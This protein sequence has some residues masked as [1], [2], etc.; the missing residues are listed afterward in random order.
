MA[1]DLRTTPQAICS[2]GMTVD[3]RVIKDEHIQQMAD[4]YNAR[5]Y[6]ARINLD[7]E[8]EWGGWLAKNIYAIDLNGGMLGDVVEVRAEKNEDGVLCLYAILSPNASFVLLNQSGQAV[9]YSAEVDFDFQDTGMAY[10]VGLAATDYPACCYTTRANFNSKTR[11]KDAV[12]NFKANLDFSD[13]SPLSTSQ[14]REQKKPFSFR[15]LFSQKQD[16][17]MKPEELASALKDAL[18]EPIANLTAAVTKQGETIEALSQKVNA[19]ATDGSGDD[20]P[21]EGGQPPA[22]ESFSAED[23]KAMQDTITKLSDQVNGLAEKLNTAL[24]TGAGDDT[25][26]A[27]GSEGMDKVL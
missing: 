19:A 18:G 21:A 13:L 11:I 8:G 17:E 12:P 14:K 3:G 6:G 24:T 20:N 26:P 15:N 25:P 16:D 23:K 9:Y 1:G 27:T 10:L 4:T 22:G 7:H 2:A 5:K